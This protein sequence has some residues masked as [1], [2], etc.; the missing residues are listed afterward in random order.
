MLRGRGADTA[1]DAGSVTLI[2]QIVRDPATAEA[3]CPK[4]NDCGMVLIVSNRM[5]SVMSA[6]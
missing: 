2:R 3:L 5:W 1:S 6:G 4:R